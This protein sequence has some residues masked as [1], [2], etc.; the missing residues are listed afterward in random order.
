MDAENTNKINT[1]D[2]SNDIKTYREN[3]FKLYYKLCS[4]PEIMR[5]KEVDKPILLN[6]VWDNF[7]YLHKNVL[8][9]AT[10]IF[11]QYDENDLSIVIA[12]ENGRIVNYCH[13]KNYL[14][15]QKMGVFDFVEYFNFIEQDNDSLDENGNRKW[16]RLCLI[17]DMVN[18]TDVYRKKNGRFCHYSFRTCHNDNTTKHIK[19]VFLYQEGKFIKMSPDELK[20]Y[21]K[22]KNL[23]YPLWL[24]P[25]ELKFFKKSRL[26]VIDKV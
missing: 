6:F 21:C 26:A 15:L 10:E 17:N 24:S 23:L 7:N 1:V 11:P 4:Y 3:F 19:D 14:A 9:R 12:I 5:I 18:V 8:K 2:V 22:E 20:E 25:P 13:M 16:I